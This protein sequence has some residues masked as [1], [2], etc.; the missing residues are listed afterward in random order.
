MLPPPPPTPPHPT[1]P[2]P[3]AP[4]VPPAPPTHPTP[5]APPPPPPIPL[6]GH[7]GVDAARGSAGGKE[8]RDGESDAAWSDCLGVRIPRPPDVPLPAH[9]GGGAP[10]GSGGVTER[11]NVPVS[12]GL[13]PVATRKVDAPRVRKGCGAARVGDRDVAAPPAHPA[14]PTSPDPN[15]IRPDGASLVA[16]R[17]LGRAGS[18]S[19]GGESHAAPAPPADSASPGPNDILPDVRVE[20][21]RVAPPSPGGGNRL[22]VSSPRSFLLP[23]LRKLRCVARGGL[24]G[25]TT[26]APCQGS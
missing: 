9:R 2:T 11:R 22:F 21:T 18:L 4:P 19:R 14:P 12:R 1:P 25:G 16:T 6:P 5:P 23:D 15:D 13:S 20:V 7:F 26:R 10:A 8:L 24:S 17:A 3:V